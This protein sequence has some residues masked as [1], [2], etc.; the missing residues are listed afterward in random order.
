[1]FLGHHTV[2]WQHNAMYVGLHVPNHSGKRRRRGHHHRHKK[3]R[4]HAE[5]EN[6]DKPCM[7]LKYRVI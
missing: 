2:N 3:E 4:D 1:M 7:Y 6:A 5:K